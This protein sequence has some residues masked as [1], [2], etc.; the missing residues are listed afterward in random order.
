MDLID[1]FFKLCRV[2]NLIF[3]SIYRA[4]FLQDQ[5]SKNLLSSLYLKELYSKSQLKLV[6]IDMKKNEHLVIS[7]DQFHS[8]DIPMDK[9]FALQASQELIALLGLLKQCNP[10]TIFEFGLM[11]GGSLY[12]FF[13]NTNSNVTID[14]LDINLLNLKAEVRDVIVNHSRITIHEGDSR[15]FDENSFKGLIDF[16]FID[17][18]HDYDVVKSDTQKAFNMLS[19]NGVIVWDDYSPHFPGVYKLIN[20]LLPLHANLFQIKGTS[21]VFLRMYKRI[22]TSL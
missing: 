19:P 20:E 12:H 14:S 4:F 2:F 6:S 8:T 17:G 16:I 3:K 18:C 9:R 10:S 5:E 21:L 1:E 7:F 15:L 11:Y 22:G 13:L